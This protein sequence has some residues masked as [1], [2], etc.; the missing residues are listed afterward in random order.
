MTCGSPGG[1]LLPRSQGAWPRGLF[2]FVDTRPHSFHPLS[3][4]FSCCSFLLSSPSP[5]ETLPPG[6]RA[7]SGLI[8]SVGRL[9]YAVLSSPFRQVFSVGSSNTSLETSVA[10][11]LGLMSKSSLFSVSFL[12]AQYLLRFLC[13]T[14]LPFSLFFLMKNVLYPCDIPELRLRVACSAHFSSALRLRAECPKVLGRQWAW[15]WGTLRSLRQVF[16][17]ADQL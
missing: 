4:S 12:T 5:S 10:T 16:I 1:G 11:I 15:L 13:G 17:R 3:A 2:A 14:T 6:C 8:P 7:P 9:P